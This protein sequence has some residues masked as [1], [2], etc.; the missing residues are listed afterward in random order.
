MFF[1]E[2]F[3]S[4]NFEI[5]FNLLNASFPDFFNKVLTG[6]LMNRLTKDIYNIDKE[7]PNKIANTIS[8]IFGLIAIFL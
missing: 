2:I 3:L 5:V 7:I 6:R 8:M 1:Y 4:T